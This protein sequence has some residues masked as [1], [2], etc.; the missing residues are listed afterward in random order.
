M[1]QYSRWQTGFAWSPGLQYHKYWY[2]AAGVQPCEFAI[3]EFNGNDGM[4]IGT[5]SSNL[6]GSS[7]G[8]WKAMMGRNTS[9]GR[10]H[11]LEM[12]LD[13]VKGIADIWIDSVLRLHETRVDFGS[14]AKR[15]YRWFS[16]PE[17]QRTPSNG[18]AHFLEDVDDIAVSV[19]G[20][21]G[22]TYG[23]NVP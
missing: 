6:N 2:F 4:L 21:I 10:W 20:R 19:A 13:T 15:G 14:A 17:N 3:P 22:C 16:S 18:G 23:T 11:C 9:N 5:C 7:T 12:H 8:G 1:R